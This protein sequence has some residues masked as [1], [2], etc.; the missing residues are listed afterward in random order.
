MAR[1]NG[2]R[3][4][5]GLDGRREELPQPVEVSVIGA[6]MRVVVRVHSTSVVTV[7]GTVLGTVSADNQ[8]FV[9]KG[10]RVEGDVAGREVV[11]DGEVHGSV[12]ARE[13]LEIQASAVV[14]GELHAPRLMVHEGA[15]VGCDVS[16]GES[17]ESRAPSANAE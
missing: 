9:T 1:T 14:L 6:G 17:R 5:F 7:A 4:H 11:L 2:L 12:D 8:V 16:T 3:S 10:G 13:R 15:V